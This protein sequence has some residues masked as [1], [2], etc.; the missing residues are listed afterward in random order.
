MKR[1]AGG[2]VLLLTATAE[3]QGQKPGDFCDAIEGELVVSFADCHVP[4][5]ADDLRRCREGCPARF[6]GLNSH[7]RT[8]TAMV[9]DVPVS[10]D[11]YLLALRAYGERRG[12]PAPV[13]MACYFGTQMLNRAVT[14]LPGT[15]LSYAGGKLTT[16]REPAGSWRDYVATASSVARSFAWRRHYDQTMRAAGHAAASSEAEGGT[17]GST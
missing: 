11:D 2:L 9:R 15:V 1:H 7:E 8:T 10:R 12:S 4:A 16:R 3:T 17:D 13:S 6:F 14:F 5:H